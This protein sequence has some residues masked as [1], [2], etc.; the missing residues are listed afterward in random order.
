LN[1]VVTT[2]PIA[3]YALLLAALTPASIPLLL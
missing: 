3:I 2:P 1:R